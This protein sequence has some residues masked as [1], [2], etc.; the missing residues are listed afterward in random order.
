MTCGVLKRAL[1]MLC[2]ITQLN[3]GSVIFMAHILSK[4][5]LGSQHQWKQGFWVQLKLAD[6]PMN[7]L[8]SCSGYMMSPAHIKSAVVTCP[9]TYN[10]MS[11]DL[12]CSKRD[13]KWMWMMV[14]YDGTMPKDK[15]TSLMLAGSCVATDIPRST[16]RIFITSFWT[17]AHHLLTPQ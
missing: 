13:I 10:C 11:F 17:K 7:M 9:S 4:N 8:T 3:Q 15:K 14:Q 2:Y 5:S 16:L 12:G 6:N 1:P